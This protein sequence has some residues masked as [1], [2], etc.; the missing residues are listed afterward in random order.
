MQ[1]KGSTTNMDSKH[2]HINDIVADALRSKGWNV[3][4]NIIYWRSE[5]DLF[6]TKGEYCIIGETK[7]NNKPSNYRK[8]CCQLDWHVHYFEPVKGYSYIKK[9]YIYHVEKDKAKIEVI[10]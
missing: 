9:L 2:D 1:H 8:A 3:Q 4:T 7:Y 6:A 5:V 10:N